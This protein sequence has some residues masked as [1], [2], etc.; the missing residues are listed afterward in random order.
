MAKE[1]KITLYTPRELW[2]KFW[3]KFF[4][5][6]RKQCAEWL[7][8]GQCEVEYGIVRDVLYKAEEYGINLSDKDC[9]KLELLIKSKISEG[10]DKLK[11]VITIP[12][13]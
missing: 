3:N 5:P 13:E 6:R 12:M 8:Y 2:V 1:I 4:W 7:E 10:F 11:K 9:E